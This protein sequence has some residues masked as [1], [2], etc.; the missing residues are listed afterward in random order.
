M[1]FHGLN[2]ENY[3]FTVRSI[4]HPNDNMQKYKAQSQKVPNRLFV[5]YDYWLKRL[6]FFPIDRTLSDLGCPT[7]ANLKC[8][9]PNV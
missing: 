5:V 8:E 9:I 2:S 3:K 1:N 6:V 4:Y 7:H